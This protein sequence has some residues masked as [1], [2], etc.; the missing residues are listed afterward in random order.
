MDAAQCTNAVNR[1]DVVLVSMLDR[2]ASLKVN[3][4]RRVKKGVFDVVD[5]ER[6]TGE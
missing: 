1:V 3:S 5:S 4:Q 2:H 6:V